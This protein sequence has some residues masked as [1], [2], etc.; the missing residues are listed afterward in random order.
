MPMD[1]DR[2]ERQ[3]WLG[4]PAKSSES[5]GYLYQVASF[6][7]SFM[8]ECR[9]DQREDGDI[10]DSGS[11]WPYYSADAIWPAVVTI[12]PD[13]FSQFYGDNHILAKNYPM[14][15]KMDAPAGKE[16]TPPER[17]AGSRR[18]QL[19]RLGR[20]WKHRQLQGH[21]IPHNFRRVDF[22]G[23]FPL[24]LPPALEICRKV[25]QSRRQSIFCGS[26]GENCGGLSKAFL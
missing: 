6:Y 24:Q 15:K 26:S 17:D 13:W 16:T 22:L 3:A 2:D 12:L 20:G 14:M 21:G 25:G 23:L 19:R 7:Q 1:P 4:H 10:S 18:I 9:I 8:G 11:V 5:E